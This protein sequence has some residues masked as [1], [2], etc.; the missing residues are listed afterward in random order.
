M[1]DGGTLKVAMKNPAGVLVTVLGLVATDVP[2]NSIVIV[3]LGSN[4]APV[5][6]TEVPL[7]PEGGSSLITRS[8]KDVTVNVFEAELDPWVAL[9]VLSPFDK[10]SGT[11]KE[12]VNPPLEL[13]VT[14]QTLVLLPQGTLEPSKLIA[15][16][17]IG[18][19]PLPVTVTEVPTGPELGLSEM[20]GLDVLPDVEKFHSQLSSTPLEAKQ[21]KKLPF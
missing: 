4:P 2:S 17:E 6:V 12:V 7:D 20:V 14:R 21:S 13:G 19:N 10:D 3:E 18:S 8:I 11:S 9:T 1:D 15:T 5:T 16:V